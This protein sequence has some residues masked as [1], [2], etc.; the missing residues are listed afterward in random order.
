VRQPRHIRPPRA[1]FLATSD[2]VH[3]P[4][5]WFFPARMRCAL[6]RLNSQSDALTSVENITSSLGRSFANWR[7]SSPKRRLTGLEEIGVLLDHNGRSMK[8]VSAIPT[9]RM[10]D[11]VAE[12]QRRLAPKQ[13]GA[14]REF[15]QELLKEV[16]VRGTNVTLTYKLPLAASECR[17]FTS[18]RL[19]GPPGLELLRGKN[20]YSV[21][22]VEVAEIYN[23]RL[24]LMVLS[25][26][27]KVP[28]FTRQFPQ[29]PKRFRFPKPHDH[30]PSRDG[31]VILF[32]LSTRGFPPAKKKFCEQMETPYRFVASVA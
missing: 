4:A 6:R 29:K 28:R 18:L 21:K 2:A 9:A 24:R 22:V 17:F 8:T 12:M 7:I 1:S 31:Q 23:E 11:Y 26:S 25:V 5:E 13:I 20:R 30:L 15:L 3:G 10:D 19:V 14:K 32:L 16:R 27:R